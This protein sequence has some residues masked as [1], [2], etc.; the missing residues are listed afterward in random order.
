LIL[1]I[2]N[3]VKNYGEKPSVFFS[4]VVTHGPLK[5]LFPHALKQIEMSERLIKRS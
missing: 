3:S 4:S 1:Q 2:N 5:C